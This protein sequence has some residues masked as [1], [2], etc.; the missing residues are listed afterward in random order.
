M[1][2]TKIDA[3]ELLQPLGDK[4]VDLILKFI[5]NK[6]NIKQRKSYAKEHLNKYFSE[7]KFKENIL[8]L[9]EE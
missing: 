5:T 8:S 3:I 2:I 1:N 9:F 6:Q 7:Q 4:S